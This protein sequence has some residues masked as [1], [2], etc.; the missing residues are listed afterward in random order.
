MRRIIPPALRYPLFFVGVMVMISAAFASKYAPSF[1]LG[2]SFAVAA[3]GF[4]LFVV[5]IAL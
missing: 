5:S 4:I 3:V 1:T 2:D